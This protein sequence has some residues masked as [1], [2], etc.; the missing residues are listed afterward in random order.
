M[1]KETIQQED[2]ILVNI[3]AANIAEPKYVKQILMDIKGEIDKNT[4]IVRDFNT[5]LTLMDRFSRQKIN[6]E[7]AALND[8]LHQMDLIHIFRAVRHKAAEYTYFSSAHGT[9]SRIDYM[10]GY[11]TSLNTFRK[12]EIISSIFSDHNTMN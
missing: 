7:T 8:T 3:Y 6:K 10:L 5:P 1:T 2:I 12:I 11:K 9:L 4:G